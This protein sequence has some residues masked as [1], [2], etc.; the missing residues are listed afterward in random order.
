MNRG[1]TTRYGSSRRVLTTDAIWAELI[2]LQTA[3]GSACHKWIVRHVLLSPVRSW[4]R[5]KSGETA[6]RRAA[7]VSSSMRAAYPKRVGAEAVTDRDPASAFLAPQIEPPSLM[8]GTAAPAVVLVGFGRVDLSRTESWRRKPDV[9][10]A[11]HQDEF[12]AEAMFLK[13]MAVGDFTGRRGNSQ[14]TRPLSNIDYQ[15]DARPH[16]WHPHRNRDHGRCPRLEAGLN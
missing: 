8:M 16:S 7:I 3:I 6:A 13:V 10:L 14:M 5:G 11:W 12:A 15:R 9:F 1:L 2:G 4:G